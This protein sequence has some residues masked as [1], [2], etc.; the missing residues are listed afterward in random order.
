MA[1]IGTKT[2]PTMKKTGR[3]VEAVRMG[4]HAFSRCCL[5]AVSKKRKI[6]TMLCEVAIEVFVEKF[7]RVLDAYLMAFA[8]LI[9][10]TAPPSWML[11]SPACIKEGTTTYSIK[12]GSITHTQKR[13]LL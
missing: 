3:A 4:C 7:S 12:D 2:S 5:N 6:T 8:K 13:C 1:P 11:L 10:P 9:Y